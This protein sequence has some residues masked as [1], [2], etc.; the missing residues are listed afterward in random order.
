MRDFSGEDNCSLPK[1]DGGRRE[2]RPANVGRMPCC[3]CNANCSIDV[4]AI[5]TYTDRMAEEKSMD[6][7][8][9]KKTWH[10]PYSGTERYVKEGS[11]EKTEEDIPTEL[12]SVRE[13][14][15]NNKLFTLIAEPGNRADCCD[16]R[17][18]S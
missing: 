10:H 11:M 13:S 3:A 18:D 6:K 5:V 9:K 7:Y 15:W 4:G 14:F 12:W 1:A 2:G 16:D 8:Q 17:K